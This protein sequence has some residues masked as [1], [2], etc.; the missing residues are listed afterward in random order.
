MRQSWS[1]AA[2]WCVAAVVV[3][4]WAGPAHLSRQRRKQ[5]EHPEEAPAATAASQTQGVEE[6]LK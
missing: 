1:L 5:E 2:V 6:V 4:L 3:V